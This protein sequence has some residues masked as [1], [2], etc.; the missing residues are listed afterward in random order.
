MIPSSERYH[1]D[2]NFQVDSPDFVTG[3]L[4]RVMESDSR[5]EAGI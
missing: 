3:G 1:D 5:I 4:R 2:L